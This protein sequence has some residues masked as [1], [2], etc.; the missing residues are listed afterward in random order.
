MIMLMGIGIK[1]HF[2]PAQARDAAQLGADQRHQMIP[3]FERLVVGIALV[4]LHNSPKLPSIERFEE[5]PKDASKVSHAR[6][7]SE[8][9]QPESTRFTPD[10]SGMLRGIVNHSPDGPA[11]VGTKERPPGTN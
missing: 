6:P 1:G 5:V 10:W 9:R 11:Q 2:D 3:A 7:L 4:P 8:S